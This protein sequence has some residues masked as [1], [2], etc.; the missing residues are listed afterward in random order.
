MWVSRRLNIFLD[1]SERFGNGDGWTG[2]KA[3][4]TVAETEIGNQGWLWDG[5]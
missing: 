1:R 5:G 3:P 4:G 2:G